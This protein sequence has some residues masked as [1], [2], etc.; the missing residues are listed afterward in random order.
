[1]NPAVRAGW[2]YWDAREESESGWCVVL[3]YRVILVV[4]WA[5]MGLRLRG[6]LL[7]W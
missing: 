2:T 7:R 5:R 1:M 6:G 4:M 3:W